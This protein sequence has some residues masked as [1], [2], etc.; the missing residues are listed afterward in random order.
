MS[1][2][3]NEFA[4]QILASEANTAKVWTELGDEFE[5]AVAEINN[6]LE[7]KSKTRLTLTKASDLISLS[8][9]L[10]RKASLSL[11]SHA[12]TIAVA[13]ERDVYNFQ[14]TEDS[15]V[16]RNIGTQLFDGSVSNNINTSKI[17][18]YVIRSVVDLRK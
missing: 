3:A 1:D 5:N 2:W 18:T 14:L 9:N 17:V 7:G 12:R 11:D 8:S 13:V 4:Q 6:V 10:N 15:S 16:V